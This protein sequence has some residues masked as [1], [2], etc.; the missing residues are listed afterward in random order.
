M[1]VP[2]Q[3]ELGFELGLVE[4]LLD[5]EVEGVARQERGRSEAVQR[6]GGGHQH[7]VGLTLRDA[8]QRG[9]PL[10]DQVLVRAERVVGQ[11]FPVR[12]QRAAQAGRKKGHLVDE[13][14]R[15][16]GVG[17]DD[18]GGAACGLVA[19]G[20]AGQQQG[21]GAAHGAGQGEAFSGGEFGEFHADGVV[22]GPA[23]SP[24]A[25]NTHGLDRGQ[26]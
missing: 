12:E 3:R 15:V 13:P 20:Q 5:L 10:A 22:S 24:G 14:L 7:H 9:Q 6:R 17:R 4:L 2:R 25:R 1:A 16:G 18:G 21:V 8:P 26:R 11:R 19:F 23:A